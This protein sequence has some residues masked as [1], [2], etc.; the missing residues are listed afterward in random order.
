MKINRW[1]LAFLG[2][3]VLFIFYPKDKTTLPSPLE[4]DKQDS[5][6]YMKGV[7]IHLYDKDGR[8]LSQLKSVKLAHFK[9]QDQSLLEAP[10]IRLN[11]ADGSL[12]QL[13]A[14]KGKII[15]H[16]HQIELIDQVAVKEILQQQVSTQIDTQYLLID[17]ENTT[18][19]TDDPITIS[20]QYYQ[21]RSIGMDMDFKNNIIN[22][23]RKVVTEKTP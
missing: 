18:A 14:E 9:H 5:D 11:Q 2:L 10:V 4:T 12:W 22:L 15:K 23:N 16:K 3:L 13:Q 21:T 20:H 19:T 8:Q 7:V 6:Y 1:Y 17:L